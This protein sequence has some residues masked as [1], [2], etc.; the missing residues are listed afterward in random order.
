MASLRLAQRAPLFI[1]GCLVFGGGALVGSA[2]TSDGRWGP[3]DSEFVLLAA[4]L[5]AYA[6]VLVRRV[7][8]SLERTLHAWAP[9]AVQVALA[10]R[11]AAAS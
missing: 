4:V 6:V 10:A 11:D 3:L 1:A 2:L 5:T 9:P 8:R 7:V